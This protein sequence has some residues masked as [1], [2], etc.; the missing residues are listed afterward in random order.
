MTERDDHLRDACG[1]VGIQHHSE[2]ARLAYLGL[3]A[4]QHRGQESA[5]IVASDG[6]KLTRHVAMGLV[7]DVFDKTALEPL[8]GSL[9]IGHVRYSTA[10]GSSLSNAQ[11]LLA[12]TGR[13]T[14]AGAPNCHPSDGAGPPGA[15]DR[16]RFGNLRL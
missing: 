13:G 4:L 14:L 10:G 11:P 6:Q 2:A 16:D 8:K 7:A 1:V 5:G 15:G 9:A 12:T 3:Y